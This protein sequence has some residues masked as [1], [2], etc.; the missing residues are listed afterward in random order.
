MHT[1]TTGGHRGAHAG[2]QAYPPFIRLTEQ[3]ARIFHLPKVVYHWRRHSASA[4][5]GGLA[6]PD[7]W[8]AGK[9]AVEEHLERTGQSAEVALGD[10]FG[11]LDVRHRHAAAPVEIVVAPRDHRAC[12]RLVANILRET[13][14]DNFRIRV[15]M[16][17]T[18]AASWIENMA[19]PERVLQ[20]AYE[21][22]Y[23]AA[24]AWNTAARA[25]DAKIMVFMDEQIGIPDGD[26][27][28]GFLQ[29]ALRTGVG[30]VG[31]FIY[32]PRGTIVHS[33]LA[34]DFRRVYV[35][36]HSGV[37]RRSGGY[38]YRARTVQNVTA[39]GPLCWAT[40][41]EVF[42]EA[43]GL[44]ETLPPD[45]AVLDYCLRLR[46]RD[47][48]MVYTPATRLLFRGP[49]ARQK[50]PEETVRKMR[51]KWGTEGLRDRYFDSRLL[52]RDDDLRA[53]AARY[54]PLR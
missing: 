40:A 35:D 46:A 45:F 3:S 6:K 22:S 1:E 13:R 43:G 21:G 27:I 51:E 42:L 33:G 26:W 29:H 52:R 28:E 17:G 9:R 32:G 7:A 48:R 15:L 5:S 34:A 54:F 2:A 12:E 31:P 38:E 18:A 25:T 37:S 50:H 47:Y 11:T 4:A 30:A 23:N 24:R 19:A 49:S 44:D 39:V 14:Y 20:T 36:F 10:W 41:R 8:E 16:R 53:L